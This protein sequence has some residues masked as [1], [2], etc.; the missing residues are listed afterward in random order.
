MVRLRVIGSESKKSIP[1]VIY[2]NN[3]IF[4]MPEEKKTIRIELNNADTM[5]EK[6][7]VVLEGLN[8]K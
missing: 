7:G 3:Y 6:P 4:L 1:P 5:G 8:I 2:S